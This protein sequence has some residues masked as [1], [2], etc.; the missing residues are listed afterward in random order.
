MTSNRE[1]GRNQTAKGFVFHAKFRNHRL[2]SWQTLKEVRQGR[3]SIMLMFWTFS[4]A[5]GSGGNGLGAGKLFRDSCHEAALRVDR[6]PTT[7]FW[8]RNGACGNG[9]KTS[10]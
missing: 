9:G 8:K 1:E 5:A 10:Q 6:A 2:G 7:P 4:L 3:S